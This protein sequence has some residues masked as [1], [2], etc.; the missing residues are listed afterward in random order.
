MKFEKF[1]KMTGGRGVFVDRGDGRN[2]L[3]FDGV[4]MNVP[5]G[6]NV[7]AALSMGGKAFI[8]HVFD[9]YNDENISTAD[10]T[11]AVLPTP[12]ASASKVVRV[13]TDAD[14]GEIGIQNKYFGLIEKSDDVYTVYDEEY[15]ENPAALLIL[16][17]Y[18]DNEEIAGII[19]DDDY[20]AARIH[21]KE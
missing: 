11:G 10:L 15:S 7:I 3:L 6:M 19:F 5:D 4:I 2:L 1:L 21:E 20:F 8:D 12:D 9:E 14:G 18:G 13:F 16:T 17:G